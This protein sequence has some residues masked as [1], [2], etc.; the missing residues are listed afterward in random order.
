M[1]THLLN[2]ARLLGAAVPL[3][4]ALAA[5]KIVAPL[6]P[7]FI[8]WVESLGV[9]G[10]VAF[11]AVYVLGVICLMPVFLLT[12]AGGAVFGV[13]RSS[14]FV[15]TG[16]LTGALFAFLIARYLARDIVA[17][18]I[19]KHPKLLAIDRAVGVHGRRLVLFLRLSPVVPFVLT[20]YV[21]GAS[22]VRLPDF[23]IGTLGL[24]PIVVTYSALGKAAGTT[25]AMTGR[26]AL[27]LPLL[28]VGVVATVFLGRFMA[29][30]AKR[31]LADVDV[32]TA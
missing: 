28:V 6:L 19:A 32:T 8:Q 14:L 26:P 18:H 15:M 10:P 24:A 27:P 1:R 29:R 17:R 2:A 23:M 25:D 21:L 9:W 31:A 13:M 22:R 20:N 3:V 4:G 11:V 12:I 30:I 7:A 5:G 16:S